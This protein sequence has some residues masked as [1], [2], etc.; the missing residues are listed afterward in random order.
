MRGLSELVFSTTN[1]CTAKCEDCPIVP[2]IDPPARIKYEDMIR[3]VGPG[4]GQFAIGSF[5]RR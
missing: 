5:H 3:I 4:L 2:S 1:R